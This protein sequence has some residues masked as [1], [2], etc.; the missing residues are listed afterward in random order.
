MRQFTLHDKVFNS[1]LHQ[2]SL[3]DIMD[4]VPDLTD[5]ETDKIASLESGYSLDL[6]SGNIVI[7]RT[8]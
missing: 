1:T 2:K 3:R 8:A 7:M 4:T 6:D 5:E